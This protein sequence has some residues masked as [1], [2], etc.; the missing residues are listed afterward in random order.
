LALVAVVLLF[1]RVVVFVLERFV[2]AD[3]FAVADLVPERFALDD[4]FAVVDFL[5]AVFLVV[6]FLVVLATEVP[7]RLHASKS[8]HCCLVRR[9]AARATFSDSFPT[10]AFQRQPERA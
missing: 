3:P 7:F 1:A 9:Q 10:A 8:V 6:V 5:L 2:L 4:S